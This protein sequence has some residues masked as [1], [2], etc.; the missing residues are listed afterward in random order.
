M[1][2]ALREPAIKARLQVRTVLRGTYRNQ[3]R[4]VI[5][6]GESIVSTDCVGT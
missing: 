3:L 2:V 5:P 6:A 4:L 1:H